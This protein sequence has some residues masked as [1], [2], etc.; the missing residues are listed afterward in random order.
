[1]AVAPNPASPSTAGEPTEVSAP[2]TDGGKTINDKRS[3]AGRKERR[4]D[5]LNVPTDYSKNPNRLSNVRF[6]LGE[7][8]WHDVV[9]TTKDDPY[10][11]VKL[12]VVEGKDPGP[13][14]RNLL[15]G[16]AR[17][18]VD[19]FHC[20]EPLHIAAAKRVKDALEEGGYRLNDSVKNQDAMIV[21]AVCVNGHITQFR[22]DMLAPLIARD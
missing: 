1:M 19:C 8:P 10:V 20:H 5:I 12:E 21:A 15:G 18:L 22:G 16:G 7:E 11:N 6:P 4:K 13:N 3:S 17:L 14:Q 9:G 2:S